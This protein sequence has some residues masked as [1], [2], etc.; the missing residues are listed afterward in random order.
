MLSFASA[1]DAM[2]CAMF[3]QHLFT[4]VTPAASRFGKKNAPSLS[5]ISSY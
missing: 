1:P 5:A 3:A 2:A 4:W